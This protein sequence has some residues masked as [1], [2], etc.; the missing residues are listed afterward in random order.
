MTNYS[1]AKTGKYPSDRYSPIFKSA[2]VAHSI[3]REN[4]FVYLPL[5]IICSLK[6]TQS[7]SVGF[8]GEIM[9]ANKYPSIFSRKM[10]AFVKI[11]SCQMEALVLTE[12][13][14][15]G[16]QQL[17]LIPCLESIS[18]ALKTRPRVAVHALCGQCIMADMW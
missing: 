2:R 15:R 12:F 13:F 17:G 14:R 11:F 6:L 5:D 3:W 1:P 16:K 7:S 8:S 18:L 9:S 10:E 4:M